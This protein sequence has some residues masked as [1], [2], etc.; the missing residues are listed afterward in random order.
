MLLDI[1]FLAEIGG[2][3]SY[4][5]LQSNEFP[6]LIAAFAI[7]LLLSLMFLSA[8]KRLIMEKKLKIISR[9]IFI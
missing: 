4:S 2:Q 9:S 8:P 6:G 1:C 7:T 3:L 5:F